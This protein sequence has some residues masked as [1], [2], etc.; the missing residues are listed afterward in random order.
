MTTILLYLEFAKLVISKIYNFD[1]CFNENYASY[2]QRNIS[3][4]SRDGLRD[5]LLR[6]PMKGHT[7]QE[8]G[9]T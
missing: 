9:F 3:R 6:A 1:K 8:V 2:I 7:S 5:D 4:M